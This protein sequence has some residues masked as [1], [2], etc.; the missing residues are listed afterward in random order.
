MKALVIGA[1]GFLG[2]Y[3][4]TNCRARGWNTEAAY[5]RTHDRIPSDCIAFPV[6]E[7]GSCP[8]DYDVIFLVAAAVPYGSLNSSSK[9][10]LEANVKL[11]LTAVSRFEQ[12][13][14]VFASSVSVYGNPLGTIDEL[15]PFNAPNL[16][17][18]SKLAGEF[19]IRQHRRYAI[20]RYS[21]LYGYGMTPDIFLPR[22]IKQ[23]AGQGTIT[24]YGSGERRQDYLHVSDAAELALHA[25]LAEKNGIY[26]GV[27][28]TSVTNLEAAQVVQ[29]CFPAC[30]IIFTGVD[31]S[32]SFIYD[33]TFT[34][35]KLDFRPQHSLTSGIKELCNNEP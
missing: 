28:G 30:N 9:E 21:S 26:L 34:R 22:I 23:A 10:L 19:I 16:Y 20:L 2:R 32:P 25:A 31:N 4:L 8:T 6:S 27:H 35:K 15:S 24:L 29:S 7:L 14:I 5:H 11:V 17:G 3:I 12:A 18:L 1:N 13:K 33:N